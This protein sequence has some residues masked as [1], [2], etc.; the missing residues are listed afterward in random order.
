MDEI[1]ENIEKTAQKL[2]DRARERSGAGMRMEEILDG[3]EPNLVASLDHY[4]KSKEKAQEPENLQ[5]L[6]KTLEDFQKHH[7]SGADAG[8]LLDELEEEFTPEEK[9]QILQLTQ[10]KWQNLVAAMRLERRLRL[11]QVIQPKTEEEEYVPES[12]KFAA[13]KIVPGKE[14]F[15]T[16]Q[17]NI[18]AI[19][20]V[21]NQDMPTIQRGRLQQALH[22]MEIRRNKLKEQYETLRQSTP[23][24]FLALGLR[25]LKDYKKQSMENKIVKFPSVEKRIKKVSQL[26]AQRRCVFLVGETGHGKTEFAIVAGRETTG[27]EPVL[28]R[29]HRK[30]RPH[31]LMGHQA[32]VAEEFGGSEDYQQ[33]VEKVEEAVERARE[34]GVDVDEAD[35]L[36][37][38]LAAQLREEVKVVSRFIEGAV[39]RCADEGRV[40]IVDESTYIPPETVALLN[41]AL[42]VRPGETISIQEDGV[43]PHEREVVVKKGFGVIFTGN[44]GSKY[45]ERQKLDPAFRDRVPVI[46]YGPLQQAETGTLETASAKDKELYILLLTQLMDRIGNIY[47]PEHCLQDLWSLASGAVTIQKYFGSEE[48][49]QVPT[50]TGQIMVSLKDLNL[51]IRGLLDI[52]QSWKKDPQTNL[53]YHVYDYINRPD[54]EPQQRA[55]ML[56]V[57][58][59]RGLFGNKDVWGVKG[60]EMLDNLTKGK[61]FE[62]E[63]IRLDQKIEHL[64]VQ[65]IVESVYGQTPE[66]KTDAEK[67][68]IY[69][70]LE[71]EPL[72]RLKER[73]E[74]FRGAITAAC[75]EV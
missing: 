64:P 4:M 36:Q 9:K 24:A 49:I 41:R 53:S 70:I 5:E 13:G 67:D 40:L 57:L 37:K 28:I 15:E 17:E 21:L 42:N 71:E 73:L 43:D 2:A 60:R 68:P 56:S 58:C 11:G 25:E 22:K 23:E 32:L 18:F 52:V 55:A 44:V 8:E 26:L 61:K 12:E 10:T 50:A 19:R 72:V 54:V 3:M 66:R 74:F 63:K 27:Q 16:L 6:P 33:A 45:L 29:G 31:E 51:S 35:I 14:G 38:T 75:P 20:N 1:R 30:M 47:A 39:Y 34:K 62:P 7:Y 69:D 59:T 48:K 65:E 46:E